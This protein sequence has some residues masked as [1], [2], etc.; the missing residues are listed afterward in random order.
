LG[1]V[2]LFF[3]KYVGFYRFVFICFSN[4]SL[5]IEIALNCQTTH[6]N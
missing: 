3:E 4:V 2:W 1:W 6:Y 5:D